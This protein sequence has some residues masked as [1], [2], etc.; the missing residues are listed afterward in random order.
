MGSRV[1]CKYHPL[2]SGGVPAE[3]I[4]P[5]FQHHRGKIDILLDP[6]FRSYLKRYWNTIEFFPLNSSLTSPE[7]TAIGRTNAWGYMPTQLFAL[8][9]DYFSSPEPHQQ[10]RT[11]QHVVKALKDDG[12]SVITDLVP[13]HTAEAGS[14]AHF[15]LRALDENRYYLLYSDGTDIDISGCG[16]ALNTNNPDVQRL[17]LDQSNYFI[18][19]F[20]FDRRIDQAA[21]AH[22]PA[23]DPYGFDPEHPFAREL[24]ELGPCIVELA[25]PGNRFYFRRGASLRRSDGVYSKE[26]VHRNYQ[27]YEASGALRDPWG[28]RMVG[29]RAFLQ[30]GSVGGPHTIQQNDPLNQNKGVSVLP[31][32]GLPNFDRAEIGAAILTAKRC[33][34][35]G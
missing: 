16:N 18:H 6:K 2:H 11:L 26:F 1:I 9:P 10:I 7:L 4:S 19:T 17:L 31:H 25:L 20:G 23:D 12:I 35:N 21:L 3:C 32:D 15:G 30:A 27:D 34:R 24:F 13:F 5:E 22:T 14:S 8:N 28:H 29:L 33:G